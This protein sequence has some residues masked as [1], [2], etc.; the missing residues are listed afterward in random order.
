[1]LTALVSA[2]AASLRDGSDSGLSE[3][4]ESVFSGLQ[5]SGSDSSED[6]PAEGEDGA[7]GDDSHSRM[8]ETSGQQVQAGIPS[9]RTEVASAKGF[10]EYAEDSSDE[11]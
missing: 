2:S 6:D 5:D 7:S 9:P 1:M 4:E 10:E 11:E 8:E 3:S